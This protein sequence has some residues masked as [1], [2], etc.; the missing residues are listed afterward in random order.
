M[1][2]GAV[3]VRMPGPTPGPI[4]KKHTHMPLIFL[5]KFNR[6]DNTISLKKKDE[7]SYGNPTI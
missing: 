5:K 6:A 2:P 4:K 1:M 3:G 7:V